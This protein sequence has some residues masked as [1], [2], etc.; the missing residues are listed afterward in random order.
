MLLCSIFSYA[1]IYYV[2]STAKGTK[3]GLSWTN[4]FTNLRWAMDIARSGDVIKVAAGTYLTTSSTYSDS[5]F[6]LP[7]GVSILGGYPN[8]GSP[9]DA[10]RDWTSQPT[11]INDTYGSEFVITASSIDTATVLDGF[12]VRTVSQ[13]LNIANCSHLVFNHVLFQEIPLRAITL[14]KSQVVFS[15][16][17]MDHNNSPVFSQDSSSSEFD[18]CIMTRN[19]YGGYLIY[20]TASSL[21]LINCTFVNNAAEV[22]YGS[23]AGSALVRNSIFWDNRPGS[24]PGDNREDFQGTQTIDITH[25]LTQNY[26]RDGAT[27]VLV[28]ADP[29]F[30]SVPNPAGA[31]GLYFTADDG[32]QLTAPCSPGLN[33]GDNNAVAGIS[34]DILGQPRIFNGGTV[35]L[36]AYERQA[37]PGTPLNVVY[38]NSNAGNTGSGNGSSWQ[39]AFKTLQQALLYCADTIKVAAGNYLTDDSYT[40]SV[41]NIGGKTVLL[42][43]YPSTGNPADA[44]R[45]PSQFQTFLKANYPYDGTNYT[46]LSSIV[47]AIQCDSASLLDGF[48]FNNEYNKTYP[49]I[50]KVALLISRGSNL[51]VN[52]CRFLTNSGMAADADR[53][54]V[55]KH[56]NSIITNSF[57]S[58]YYFVQGSSKSSLSIQNCTGGNNSYLNLDSCTGKVRGAVFGNLALSASILTFDSCSIKGASLKGGSNSLFNNCL[59]QPPGV[60]SASPFA[61]AVTNDSSSPV[62]TKC[63]FD[64]AALCVKNSNHS[65]PVF[66]NCVGINGQ[67]MQNTLSF[68][69]LNNCTIVNTNVSAYLS[70]YTKLNEAELIVNDDSST[71]RANNT[72]FWGSR[73]AAGTKDINN[74]VPQNPAHPDTAFLVNCIT[75]NYGTNGVNGNQV[76]VNPRFRQLAN[77][78]GKDGVMF[79]ADDGLTL[80]RCSPAINGGRNDLGTPTP[81]DILNSPRINNGTIDIGAY[82]LQASFAGSHSYYVNAAAGGSNS[83]LSWQDAYPEFQS[84]VCD[85]CADTIRVAAGTYFPAKTDRD[86][87]FYVNRP[88]VLYGGYPSSGLQSDGRRDPIANPTVLSGNIGDPGNQ[89]DNSKNIMI[90]DGVPDS[91]MI[92]GFIFRDGYS[93]GGGIS[94]TA[95]GGA[96]ISIYYNKSI[97]KNCQFLNNTVGFNGGAISFGGYSD[98]S[99]SNSVF[100]GNY[101]GSYGGAIASGS[102]LRLYNCAFDSNYSSGEGGALQLNADF[103]VRNCIF[104]KNYTTFPTV[105]GLGGAIYSDGGSGPI[106]N[107]T[108]IN[109]TSAYKYA[110]GGGAIYLTSN[111]TI[112]I[113]N[114]IF[115][116]NSSGGVNTGS[117]TDFLIENA[118]Y[119]VTNSLLQSKHG[120]IQATDLYNVDPL[121]TDTLHPRGADGRWLTADDGLQL[122]YYSPLVNYGDN[123]SVGTAV[124]VLG[125]NRIVGGTVDPGA[126]E[127]QDRPLALAGVDTLLCNGDSLKIG[128]GGDPAFSYSW[129]SAPAGFV[130]ADLMPVVKP[131]VPTRYFLSVTDGTTTSKDTVD[132]NLTG[133]LTPLVNISTDST[134]ICQGVNTIFTASSTYGGDSLHYQWQINGAPVGGDSSRFISRT[135]ANGDNVSVRLTSSISCANPRSIT[136]NVLPMKVGAV[137]APSFTF[138][139]PDHVCTGSNATIK[140]NPVNGGDNPSFVW[141]DGFSRWQGT[142]DSIV[143]NISDTLSR[144]D[145]TMT[146]GNV[147]ASP[148]QYSNFVLIRAGQTLY[149]SVLISS[150]YTAVCS[151]TM[152]QFTAQV[153]GAG[154]NPSFQWMVNNTGTGV[155]SKT[156]SSNALQNGDVVSA[157]LNTNNSCTSPSVVSSN[158][159]PMTIYKNV[160]PSIRLD[161]NTTVAP[162]QSSLLTAIISDGGDAPTFRWQDSSAIRGWATIVNADGLTLNYTPSPGSG[163]RCIMTSNALCAILRTVISDTLIFSVKSP[164]STPS[165]PRTDSASGRVYPNPVS[166]TLTVD[167]L[168]L[169][170]NWERLEIRSLD[171][172]QHVLSI[173]IRNMTRISVSVAGLPKGMYVLCL[174]RSSGS[175]VYRQVLKL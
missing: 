20:S 129:T 86:S 99:I 42:G 51:R 130:S 128:R 56:S 151:G 52:N 134:A 164:T 125:N 23:G 170:D 59:F 68:P 50:Q 18:N 136:S 70:P 121:F 58:N 110:D 88:L 85:A 79:T 116:G 27:S 172:Q 102:N 158:A 97:I 127:F 84:A 80:A 30:V 154:S 146:S 118:Y 141:S 162:N 82:E 29:R 10:Q 77:V 63:L 19:Q 11:I 137:V 14:F 109:N 76:S 144:I 94:F 117:G 32:L 104:Y 115:R 166:T 8:S 67:F 4:A 120:Y 106:Y 165:T 139:V 75:R 7:R 48:Y 64:S 113:K 55:E 69:V 72:I 81:T 49:P 73:L 12:T 15:A 43:G 44:D 145:V 89:K 138:I 62:F 57:F 160:T 112:P 41:F 78:Y 105:I 37:D 135:L 93:G 22:F 96:G 13:G 71:L 131:A 114:C 157:T 168:K 95:P 66:N 45:N 3:D 24:F 140:V 21:R 53:I 6:R 47:N 83:G 108:F 161:G 171:G 132:I 159:V 155:S 36:G 38:V 91:V 40:D 34:R 92:D 119:E 175:N 122:T 150:N 107:C 2:N 5:T 90:I 148:K 153:S 9:S 173:D 98:C 16:C 152:V 147:C 46:I 101:A 17:I 61:T 25:S 163:V 54:V 124:D 174:L 111:F 65:G 26:F 74:K 123:S 35:D 167:S 39:N 103:D 126:Y 156:F 100:A 1:N 133:S 149:P 33:S 169:S 87:T 31:D 142:V 28:N 143:T 60:G